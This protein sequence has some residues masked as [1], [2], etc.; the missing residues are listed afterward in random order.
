MAKRKTIEQGRAKSAYDSVKK[1]VDDNKG[2]STLENYKSYSK[3]VPMMIKT[4][5]LGA[6]L[7]FMKSKR[8]EYDVIYNDIALWLGSDFKLQS[9]LK[10]NSDNFLDEVLKIE[11]S[12]LYRALAIEVLAYMNWHRR[13]TEG[14]I[15]KEKDKNKDTKPSG[16]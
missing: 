12:S 4:S 14:M 9:T 1:Y 10:I 7:A 8:K 5:G 13:F 11:D 2:K 6:T 16:E 3:K 15:V